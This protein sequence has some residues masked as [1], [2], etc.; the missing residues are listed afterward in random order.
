MKEMVLLL[1]LLLR[2]LLRCL[3]LALLHHPFLF[4]L[5]ITLLGVF[6]LVHLELLL[7]LLLLLPVLL[8]CVVL[9]EALA[10]GG[11]LEEVL[12]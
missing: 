7:L 9:A 6:F 11:A 10:S 1:L 3:L 4:V 5:P 8:D 12:N 2:L